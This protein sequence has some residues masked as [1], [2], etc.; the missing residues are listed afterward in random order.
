[1]HLLFIM[2]PFIV[3][4]PLQRFHQLDFFRWA[5][6]YVGGVEILIKNLAC[7]KSVDRVVWVVME[8][9]N[10][11]LWVY[12]FNI[13]RQQSTPQL[14]GLSQWAPLGLLTFLAKEVRPAGNCDIGLSCAR[15]S[16]TGRRKLRRSIFS[17]QT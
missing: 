2:F 11:I 6:T 9:L 8:A 12:A 13:I 7:S 4:F 10:T 14:L 1:M 3:P 17:Q 15:V 16:G 5:G